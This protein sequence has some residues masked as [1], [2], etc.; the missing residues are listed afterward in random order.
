MSFRTEEK[1]KIFEDICGKP[2]MG[3]LEKIELKLGRQSRFL[4]SVF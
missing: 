2:G 4:E 3:S 1:C